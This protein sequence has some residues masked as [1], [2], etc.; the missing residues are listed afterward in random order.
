M[1]SKNKL[2]ADYWVQI[3][4]KEYTKLLDKQRV[5]G[6]DDKKWRNEIK[7]LAINELSKQ[8]K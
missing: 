6:W 4:A 3:P 5:E 2:D 1:K 8:V 7:K